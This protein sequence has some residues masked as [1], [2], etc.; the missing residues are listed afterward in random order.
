MGMLKNSIRVVVMQAGLDA[1]TAELMRRFDNV[2]Y[3]SC[4]PETLAQNLLVVKDTHVLKS[5][6]L[7]DQF[8]FT[9]HTE[10]G[11]YLERKRIVDAAW[12]AT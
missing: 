1:C 6:A 12:N 7:F 11:V 5:V 4:N 8:P 9:H 2:I 3:I 10:C